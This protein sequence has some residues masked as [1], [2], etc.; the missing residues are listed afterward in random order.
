MNASYIWHNFDASRLVDGLPTKGQFD[1]NS[2][3]AYLEGGKIYEA[4]N[5]RLQPIVALS[6]MSLTTEGYAENGASVNRLVVKGSGF[7][8]LKSMVGGRFAYP[9]EL[10]SGRRLVPELRASWSHEHLDNSAQFDARLFSF[11]ED[12]SSYFTTNGAE[13]DRDAL[14][15]GTGLNAPVSDKIVLYLDYDASLASDQ[16]SQTASGGMRILW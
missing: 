3:S 15:L 12:P 6:M 7:D 13:Y 16:T 10:D 5:W 14:I 2:V 1:G 9:I 11:A 4:D 8:S